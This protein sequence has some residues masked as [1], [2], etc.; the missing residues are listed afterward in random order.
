MAQKT[1]WLLLYV[2]PLGKRQKSRFLSRLDAF[3][4]PVRIVP[5][6]PNQPLETTGWNIPPNTVIVD[7][8]FNRPKNVDML[9]GAELYL[10]I[11][12]ARK[13]KLHNN[14]PTLQEKVWSDS[15]RKHSY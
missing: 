15:G 12:R 1:K 5:N 7:P 13:F 4:L 11:L 8:Q 2:T 9:N 6:Q 3:V 14:F 10:G